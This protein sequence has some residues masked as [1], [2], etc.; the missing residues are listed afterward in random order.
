MRRAASLAIALA[1]FAF[2]SAA[3]ANG[4]FPSANQLVIDPLDERHAAVRTTF[5]L[6]YANDGATFRWVCEKALGYEGT[7]DPAIAIAG[8][9][10]LVALPDGISRSADGCAWERIPI[11]P[12]HIVDLAVDPENALRVVAV[13][14]LDDAAPPGARAMLYESLDGGATFGRSVELPEDFHPLTVDV[15]G[16]RMYA[17]GRAPFTRLAMVIRSGDSGATWN[18]LTFDSGGDAYIAGVDQTTPDRVYLRIDGEVKDTLLFSDNG[19]QSFATILDAPELLGFAVAPDGQHVAAGGPGFGVFRAGRDHAFTKIADLSV[20]C[21]T[22]TNAA[23][24]ACAT[25][26]V[27]GFALAR[28][29]EGLGFSPLLRLADLEPLSCPSTS[30]TGAVCPPF[31]PEISRAIKPPTDAGIDAAADAVAESAPSDATAAGGGCGCQTTRGSGQG[32]FAGLSLMVALIA[33]R[34]ILSMRPRLPCGRSSRA[35]LWSSAS[36]SRSSS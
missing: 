22:W 8:G 26:P 21:L 25:D 29:T 6:L 1:G 10:V 35:S 4:R 33:W 5:G 2:A 34:G 27:D 18:E 11:A 16:T 9:K 30:T 13:T 7:Y 14:A 17:S 15:V 24:Y 3:S 31:W 20:R 28:S 23:L 19:A 36:P 12:V 32:P